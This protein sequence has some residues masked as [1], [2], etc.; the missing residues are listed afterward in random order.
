MHR[1]LLQDHDHPLNS[2]ID[3]DDEEEDKRDF[4]RG[5]QETEQGVEHAPGQARCITVLEPGGPLPTQLAMP[6]ACRRLAAANLGTSPRCG[7]TCAMFRGR[8]P[9]GEQL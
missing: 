6:G 2:P 1:T 9:Y 4:V 8:V 5:L 7:W 3:E